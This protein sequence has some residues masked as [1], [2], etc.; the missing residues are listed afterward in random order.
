M[1]G[2]CTMRIQRIQMRL[3]AVPLVLSKAIFRI[4]LVHV[5]TQS[6]TVHLGQNRSCR[7][8]T[9]FGIALHNRFS[10]NIQTRQGSLGLRRANVVTAILSGRPAIQCWAC[11][12]LP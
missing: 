8:G 10:Q 11:T 6:V 5:C 9:D 7:N 2:C 4:G 12:D 3:R 1:Q